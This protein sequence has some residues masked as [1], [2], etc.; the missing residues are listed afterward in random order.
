[1]AERKRFDLIPG[2]DQDALIVGIVAAAAIFIALGRGA[3]ERW[4]QAVKLGGPP[5]AALYY[6]KRKA[7]K[8][9]EMGFEEGYNTYNP[10]LHI[11]E[12]MARDS[13][14]RGGGEPDPPMMQRI[15][16]GAATA[17]AT[18]V[19][20]SVTDRVI[21]AGVRD[22]MGRMSGGDEPEAAPEVVPFDP[23]P[24][25]RVRLDQEERLQRKTM[26][27]LKRMARE[28]GLGGNWLS[29]ARKGQII[30]KLLKA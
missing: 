8:A 16:Q 18:G 25:V 14:F 19:A 6:G 10:A 20:A 4:E 21:D 22:V 3:A 24:K 27:Q 2:T 23:E 17:V 29:T 26:A 13:G 9:K 12:L 7:D 30:E 1:M 28:Q 5:A 15:A 11:N